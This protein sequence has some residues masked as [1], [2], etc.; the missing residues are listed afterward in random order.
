MPTLD[1]D[2]NRQLLYLWVCVPVTG[3]FFIHEYISHGSNGAKQTQFITKL[4]SNG[5]VHFF[6]FFNDK[7]FVLL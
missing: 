7:M 6:S 5:Q 4:H 1:T 2:R 3:R